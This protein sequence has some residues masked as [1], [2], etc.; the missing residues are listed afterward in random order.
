MPGLTPT[1]TEISDRFS[2]LGFRVRSGRSPYYEVAIATDPVL[3]HPDA[4]EQRTESN[5][6]STHRAGPLPTEHGEAMYFIPPHVLRHFVGKGRLYYT[7]AAFS[8]TSRVNPEI[9][10]VPDQTRPWI[11]ISKSFTGREIRRMIGAPT[12]HHAHNGNGYGSAKPDELVWAGDDSAPG[13]MQKVELPP[14]NGA[15][16]PAATKPA[17]AG[18]PT[19]ANGTKAAAA[20]PAKASSLATET[21]FEYDDGHGQDFWEQSQED[22]SGGEVDVT[23]YGIDAPIPD[24]GNDSISQSLASAMDV[25]PE[26][27]QA[28]RF[29]PA[30]STNFYARSSPRTI[31]K[32]VIHITDG[33]P[34]IE[35]T[36][37]WFQTPNQMIN[38]KKV[39]SSAH[40]V[41]GQ[42]GEV[43]QMVR[44]QDMA[45]HASSANPDSIGI[46]HVARAPHE[47]G[48]KDPGFN[49]TDAEYCASAALVHWLCNEFNLPMDR[50]HILG[51]SE[52]DPKTTHTDC[53]N[54]VW[55]WDYYMGLVT[56]G[57]CS[58]HGTTSE[59][60]AYSM[61]NGGGGK[62]RMSATPKKK[63]ATTRA[64]E[65]VQ[66]DYAP[67]DMPGALQSQLDFQTR[68]KQ[69]FAGVPDT[70]YF[71]HSAICQLVRDDGGFGT[72]TY[73]APDRILTAAHVVE[74]A[75]SITVIP[76]KNG[77]TQND[78]PFGHFTCPSSDWAVHPNRKVGNED[79]DIAVLKVNTPP[80]G[81]QFFDILEELRQSVSSNII[82]CGYSAQSDKDPTLTATIDP[83]KQHMDGD[84]I[85]TVEDDTFTYN[86][87]S[88]H[89]ASGAAV[90]YVGVREDD[91]KR[92]SVLETHLVGVHVSGFSSTLNRGCRLTDAKIAWIQSVGQPVSAGAS[93]QGYSRNGKYSKTGA[94]VA[95][96]K[97]LSRSAAVGTAQSYGSSRQREAQK[98]AARQPTPKSLQAAVVVPAVATI[99][100]TVLTRILDNSGDIKWELDQLKGLKHPHDDP[101]NAGTERYLNG[102]MTLT[103][104]SVENLLHDAIYANFEITWQYNGHS[105]GNITINPI[106][107]NDAVAWGLAVKALIN[108]DAN[109][110]P[111]K[112]GGECSAIQ[113]RFTWVFDRVLFSDKIYITDF[114]LRGDGT[115][116]HSGRWTQ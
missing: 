88:L 7:V 58:P 89:G 93:A 113:L 47:W 99:A 38:G 27:P 1:R 94:Q 69:W 114:T 55:D 75:N 78:G 19:P 91:A 108:D 83:N 66:A 40:Y 23:K 57:T 86:L 48:K 76:G 67:A 85:R 17:A 68:Y 107:T 115:W 60:Q 79:F 101:K 70:S 3:F 59:S 73:I 15:T 65:V 36:I 11:T 28:T 61:G 41:V 18:N 31:N 100:G 63:Y 2:V 9:L 74:G 97:P 111:S 46:E 110:Y 81:G 25:A 80:P 103:G 43:V 104:P 82:V 34:K 33:Q 49:P 39:Y 50:D 112:S 51:H 44:H 95:V 64:L 12:R 13:T 26:Y 24:G 10:D 62:M 52:A 53:P 20:S 71:P 84:E 35:G 37:A 14:S 90:Y 42:N 77:Q 72:G 56:S 32:I 5:F 4:K 87:Q 29:A 96:N 116:D 16:A 8:D 6:F 92:A 98:T 105:L 30:A 109:V 54:A 102:K 106:Q 21:E 45:Y 22:D